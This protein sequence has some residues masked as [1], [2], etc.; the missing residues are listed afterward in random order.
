M[1]DIIFSV[2]NQV[3]YYL[4]T[5]ID[6]MKATKC[7]G[8]DIS[9][10]MS[11]ICG[12]H[13]ILEICNFVPPD[14]FEIVYDLF[15]TASDEAFAHHV[16]TIHTSCDLGLL[17]TLTVEFFLGI[18]ESFYN[19]KVKASTWS[20]V[21]DEGQQFM[22]VAHNRGGYK[23]NDCYNCDKK[24]GTA[25]SR[26]SPDFLHPC[27]QISP[28]GCG[29]GNGRGRGQGRR[30][31]GGRD[32]KSKGGSNKVRPPQAGESHTKVVN[33]IMEAQ[34]AEA[35][36]AEAAANPEG[37]QQSTSTISTTDVDGG[38]VS[39]VDTNTD[40]ASQQH[41]TPATPTVTSAFHGHQWSGPGF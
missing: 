10:I 16:N 13:T 2:T 5:R 28:G 8:E 37:H 25:K 6:E 20:K 17:P 22:F 11:F 24:G 23:Q 39:F 1:F 12:A 15:T 14:F 30:D 32:N 34:L 7:I 38:H 40:I 29:H 19:S 26:I 4:I 21:A 31:R 41:S 3:L 27:K 35:A 36:A 9:Q 33:D 18:V